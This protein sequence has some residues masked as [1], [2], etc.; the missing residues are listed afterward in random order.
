MKK[1]MLILLL[2]LMT[3]TSLTAVTITA[4]EQDNGVTLIG[5]QDGVILLEYTAGNFE[6]YGINIDG[7]DWQQVVLKGESEM[8]NS[9]FASLP[10]LQRSV[11][12]G[13]NAAVTVEIIASEFV[14]YEMSV[15][16]SRGILSREQDP[17][18]VPYSFGEIYNEDIYYPENRA[19]LGE[20]YILRD[21][22][23]VNLVINPF[24]YNGV[25]KMLRFYT[26]LTVEIRETGISSI[27]VKQ[28]SEEKINKNFAEIYKKHFVNYQ[29]NRYDV[30]EEDSGRMLIISHGA[31]MDAMQPFVDW[32]NQ[33]GIS[34][35][36][37]DVA[38]IG[39]SATNIQNYIS[40]EY[41]ADDGLVWVLLVG[42]GAEVL[43]ETYSGAG[44]DPQYTYLEGNDYYSEIFIGRFSAQT[45]AN[46]E[47]QVERSIY[48]ERDV[49]DGDWMQKGVGIASS[50]GS[51]SGHYG[52]ADY[53]HMGYIRDDLMD[54]GYLEVDEIYDNNGGNATMVANALNEGRGI[55][56][57]CG[58]GSNTS[59]VSTGF[60]NTY[61]NAL[62]NDYM[63]PFIQ[64]IA[65]VNGNFIGRTCFAE[66]WMRATNGDAPTGAVV[67]FAASINQSWAPPMY[68]QD[69]SIDLMCADDLNT[70]GGLWFNGVS[71]M[72]EESGDTAMARTWHIFGD[73]S[74]QVRTMTPEVINASYS[75][76]LQLMQ[77]TYTVD[78]GFANGL[79]CLSYNNEVIYKAYSEVDGVAYLFLED[80]PEE[81]ETLTLTITGYNKATLIDEVELMA[82]GGA[83][84]QM[85]GYEILSGN[86]DVLYAGESASMGI[87]LFNTG[88]EVSGE[89]E[90]EL[91]C[92]SEYVEMTDSNEIAAPIAAG[93]NISLTNCF[94]FLLSNEM[95]N[96]TPMIFD[97]VATSGEDIW[98]FTVGEIGDADANLI[99]FTEEVEIDLDLESSGNSEITFRNNNFEGDISYTV[100]LSETGGDRSIAGSTVTCDA[101]DFIPGQ[102]VDWVF[103]C[104][105]NSPDNEWMQNIEIIFPEGIYVNSA[106]SYECGT[107]DIEFLGNTG[108][109]ATSKWHGETSSGWGV[110]Y[111]GDTAEATVNVTIMSGFSGDIVMGWTLM[112]DGYAGTPHTVSGTMGITSS[113]D[114]VTW[115][116]IDGTA[117][118]LTGGEEMTHTLNFD[119]TGLLEGIYTAMITIVGD[120]NII[121]V[122]V[123][124]YAGLN[125][126]IYGD[127]DDNGYVESYDSSILLQYVVGLDP[128]GAPLP[129]ETWRELRADV[130]G[131]GDVE[132]YD[133]ALILQ[134]VVGMIAEFPA[135]NGRGHEAPMGEI[136]V[137]TYTE[138]GVSWLEF[139]GQGEVLGVNI[140]TR[141]RDF[142]LGAPEAGDGVSFSWNSNNGIYR[143]AIASES[144]LS[145]TESF[146]RI[147][148]RGYNRSG[149]L[150]IDYNINGRADTATI[151]LGGD[152]SAVPALSE[153]TGNYPNPFNPET[154]VEYSL[155]EAGEIDISI[156]NIKGQEICS[157]FSGEQEEG[158]HHILWNGMNTA[159]E[160][161]ASGTYI[162]LLKS[163]NGIESQKLVL[164][165]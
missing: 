109:G 134:Y 37:V 113:A 83:N 130:D 145:G 154:T 163:R 70:V 99:S 64:S 57:Y 46:V 105:N 120:T 75:P 100:F 98:N 142:I 155:S 158:F 151:Y 49:I 36:M 82:G 20:P 96:G 44:G 76:T 165:K 136:D 50:Q 24:S 89:I 160:T 22:R 31:F 141:S 137:R 65:C 90:L 23:G 152:N 29:T 3:I 80:L 139:F 81:P 34:T 72:I 39:N 33:K 58:H 119:T 56:N 38:A 19:D 52:E 11:I 128:A 118:T 91:S 26:N 93:G 95:L 2:A 156:Y 103:A 123:T 7:E 69:E 32:K 129:W 54:Y 135:E 74:L 30:L 126:V 53:V 153:I 14:E 117:G 12:I 87:T 162:C 60:N 86:D 21:Y 147:P 106:T 67:M 132:S 161:V 5:E 149:N 97:I 107:Y 17:A 10:K 84:V 68:A 144:S 45:V 41:D 51:S 15:A 18:E 159:G 55:I 62:T 116:T 148:V 115:I 48:Y 102:T 71:Y 104:T 6:T 110:L 122:P 85:L 111:D 35:T 133:A 27:N 9:G 92:N 138:A 114:P 88:S 43:S 108:N 61:V 40:A 13:D 4:N 131:N 101:V 63:L 164:I 143:Y 112:G 146:L 73:P 77:E 127:L 42:D 66:A 78:L 150:E 121:E 25:T 16:P 59:W 1:S 140:T 8:R 28:R 157:L 47:T 79:V 124:L 125:L 94:S